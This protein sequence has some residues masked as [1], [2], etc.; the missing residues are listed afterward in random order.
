MN[1]IKT[2]DEL[3]AVKA[4]AAEVV[5]TRVEGKDNGVK[6][7]LVCGGTG[8]TSSGPMKIIEKLQEE[9]KKNGPEGKVN[10]IKTGCFGLCALGPIMIVYP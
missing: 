2:I 4:A 3:N 8:C 1:G 5:A 10:I 9:L 6:D 7:V